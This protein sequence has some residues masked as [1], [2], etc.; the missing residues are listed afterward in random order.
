MFLEPLQ[1]ELLKISHPFRDQQCQ[2]NLLRSHGLSSSTAV[3]WLGTPADLVE[4]ASLYTSEQGKLK[5]CHCA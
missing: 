5:T 4:K 3:S 1:L 2:N